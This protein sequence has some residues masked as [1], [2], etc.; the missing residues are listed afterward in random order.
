M[1]TSPSKISIL[2]SNKRWF[3]TY[4]HTYV[5]GTF[6]SL[7]KHSYIRYW[8]KHTPKKVYQCS[9][10]GEEE[11][12]YQRAVTYAARCYHSLSTIILLLPSYAFLPLSHL[13]W[14]LRLYTVATRYRPF[15]FEGNRN[16]KIRHRKSANLAWNHHR[17]FP[18][19]L[20]LVLVWVSVVK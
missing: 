5:H 4:V 13:P 11:H 3:L 16:G 8:F 1:S 6:A 17:Q 2:C 9:L 10:K 18:P 12:L 14:T 19:Y 7:L 20:Q 15:L